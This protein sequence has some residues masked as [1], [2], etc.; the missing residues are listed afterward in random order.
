MQKATTVAYAFYFKK[1]YTSLTDMPS[2]VCL[3]PILYELTITLLSNPV[4]EQCSVI[5]VKRCEI[6]NHH[7]FYSPL[8]YFNGS[9]SISL[10]HKVDFLRITLIT[11]VLQ[12]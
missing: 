11:T 12:Y 6:F 5:V 10:D 2:V 4:C 7:N 3:H 1:P 9:V 8:Y